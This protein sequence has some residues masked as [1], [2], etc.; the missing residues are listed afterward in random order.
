[1]G[2]HSNRGHYRADLLD[3]LGDFARKGLP[4]DHAIQM[5]VASDGQSWHAWRRTPSGLVLGIAAVT[6]PADHWYYAGTQPPSASPPHDPRWERHASS[7][8]D[9]RR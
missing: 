5:T 4:E 3:I 1:M 9:W 6:D 7:F 2:H 8:P